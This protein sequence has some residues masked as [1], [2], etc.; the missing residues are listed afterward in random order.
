MLIQPDNDAARQPLFH[1]LLSSQASGRR[2]A[3]D[4]YA[5]LSLSLGLNAVWSQAKAASRLK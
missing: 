4:C 3:A 2:Q 1:Y 5:D